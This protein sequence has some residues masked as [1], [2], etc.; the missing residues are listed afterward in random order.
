M[1]K[2]EQYV[3]QLRPVLTSEVGAAELEAFLVSNSNLPGPRSNLE[4]VFALADCFGMLDVEERHLESLWRWS[5]I[6]PQEAGVNEPRSFLT[7]CAVVSLGACYSRV[8]A[9]TGDRILGVIR[10]AASD[11]RWRVREAAAFAF[12]RIAEKDF[13]TIRDVF[14]S[15]V[16]T[17]S[18]MEMRAIEASLAHPP[19]LGDRDAA[20]FCFEITDGILRYVESMTADERRTE[21]FRV[22]KKGLQYTVS[23]F[24][25]SS[26]EQ[27]FA[28][29]RKWAQSDDADVVRIIGANLSK[30]RLAK[31]FPQEVV[32]IG[33][34]ISGSSP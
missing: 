7:F 21:E 31:H 30:T 2:R 18:V 33:E 28:F 1:G 8:S 12:Q 19:I 29:L 17:A 27:G 16:K 22:L 10:A 15:W 13:G 4:L 34:T 3:D 26:P 20:E 14:S 9:G 23:V 24:A 6:S 11:P 32:E 25:A 5:E